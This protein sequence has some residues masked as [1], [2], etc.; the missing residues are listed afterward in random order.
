[1]IRKAA[2]NWVKNKKLVAD[3]SRKVVTLLQVEETKLQSDPQNPTLQN[4]YKDLKT[5]L[6]ELQHREQ[7]DLRQRA[8]VNWITQGDQWTKFFAQEIRARH[9]GNS[10]MGTIDSEGNQTHSLSEMKVRAIEYF[11]KLFDASI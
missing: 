4:A 11:T 9:A 8:H 10:I 7:M 3:S 2:K 5:K 1:M 6:D